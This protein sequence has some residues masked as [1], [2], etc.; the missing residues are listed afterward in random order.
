MTAA[1]AEFVRKLRE[2]D[3]TIELGYMP[4]EHHALAP[5]LDATLAADGI[6]AWLDAWDMYNGSGYVPS[7]RARAEAVRK[8]H[9]MN[10][11]IVWLRPNSYRPA[12]IAPS[13]YHAAAN[14]DGYS[15][16]SLA[17]LD[18]A[19]KHS[20]GMALPGTF[21]G[22]DYLSEFKRANAALRDDMAAGTLDNP[23]RIPS[24]KV[25]PL[26]APLSWEGLKVPALKPVG[27][28]TGPDRAI[29]LRDP[30]TVFI[31]A[32]AGQ[33]IRVTLGHLAGAARPISLQ[34]ALLDS[35]GSLLRNEA[36]NPGATETFAVAA[37]ETG[38]Y[39]LRVS[40]GS[41]GQAWYS[42]KVAAPLHWAVDARDSAYL[43]GLQTFYVAGTNKDG[44][45]S[46]L[47]IQSCSAAECFRVALNGG[48]AREIV[49][50]PVVDIALP[51]GVVKVTCT[52]SPV[53]DYAQNFWL[54]FPEGETPF[55]FPVRERRL[56]FAK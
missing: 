2:I 16:W 30:R 23:I 28:G 52:K 20:P 40:G 44:G 18:D 56:E 9:P 36:V 31:Y 43:F 10:R 50:T 34:Y 13:A 5:C 1:V 8:A 12:D 11:F 49:R 6:P 55:V 46:T 14:T 7:I 27:D 35:K 38:M 51:S 42:V 4:A 3:P 26:V 45:N 53:S 21:T 25:K 39:A 37:P 24:V 33:S 22:A 54:S 19:M 15:M 41:G 32:Q 17:M 47:R 48:I 29:T